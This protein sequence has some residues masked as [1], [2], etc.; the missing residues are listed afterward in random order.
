MSPTCFEIIDNF[1]RKFEK[2]SEMLFNIKESNSNF[3]SGSKEDEINFG[4]KKLEFILYYNNVKIHKMEMHNEE[5]IDLDHD[6]KGIRLDIFVKETNRMYDIEL[7]VVDTK[8]LPKRSRYY[9]GLMALDT[10]KDGE[11]YSMLRESHVIFICMTDIFKYELPVYSFEN[12]CRE[13]NEIKLN[14]QK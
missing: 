13:N 12:L 2:Y 10:L 8:E 9:V 3:A 5:T 4:Y 7:Q 6:K 1:G 14:D 11:P